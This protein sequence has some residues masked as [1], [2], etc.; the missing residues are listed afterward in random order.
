[1]SLKNV[2][3][4]GEKMSSLTLNR[5]FI[6]MFILFGEFQ[7]IPVI[8]TYRM[9]MA[10]TLAFQESKSRIIGTFVILQ[11]NHG[12]KGPIIR[13]TCFFSFS[14]LQDVMHFTFSYDVTVFFGFNICTSLHTTMKFHMQGHP[15]KTY[16]D[17]QVITS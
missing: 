17:S 13:D 11:D 3:N 14:V 9:T 6:Y 12:H 1:M 2:T 8:K 10:Y 4:I 7:F 16:Y 5:S 15:I